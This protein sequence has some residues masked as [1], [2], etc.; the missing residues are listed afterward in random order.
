[1]TDGIPAGE[2]TGT[3]HVTLTVPTQHGRTEV[4][5]HA[6]VIDEDA[7]ELFGRHSCHRLAAAIACLTGW[8]VVTILTTDAEGG[9]P[10]AAHSLVR[11]PA[12]TVADISGEYPDLATVATIAARSYTPDTRFWLHV[13]RGEDMPGE[14]IT[15]VP[16]R[17]GDRRWWTEGMDEQGSALISHYARLVISRHQ[18]H[19]HRDEPIPAAPTTHNHTSTTHTPIGGTAMSTLDD[20]RVSLGLVWEEGRRLAYLLQEAKSVAAG[21]QDRLVYAGVM[22]SSQDTPA[23]AL[24]AIRRMQDQI[25]ELT[26]SANQIAEDVQTYGNQL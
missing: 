16:D 3:A 9:R 19:T 8:D 5:L 15:G 11:T 13:G 25:D 24:A 2:F 4:T 23:N 12:G 7:R 18:R 21:M 14:V 1:M 6:G 22:E 10:V 17:R 20:L 26:A